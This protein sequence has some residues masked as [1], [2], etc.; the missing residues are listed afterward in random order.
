MNYTCKLAIVCR[1]YTDT[2]PAYCQSSL[3][4]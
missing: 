2:R 1:Q 3:Y 4:G